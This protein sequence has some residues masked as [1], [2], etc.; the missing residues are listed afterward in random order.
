MQVYEQLDVHVYDQVS[1]QVQL[2][3]RQ[4]INSLQ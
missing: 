4:Y 2:Q 3:I 1:T